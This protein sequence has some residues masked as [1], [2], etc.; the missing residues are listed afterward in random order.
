MRSQTDSQQE[1][2]MYYT[3]TLITVHVINN[4][5]AQRWPIMLSERA[6]YAE[7]VLCEKLKQIAISA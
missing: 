7:L 6:V 5:L 1:I 4:L 2:Q 3:I